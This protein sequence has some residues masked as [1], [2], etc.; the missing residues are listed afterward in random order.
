LPVTVAV[1][2][3]VVA[4]RHGV[5]TIRCRFG[6]CQHRNA[7][8]ISARIGLRRSSTQPSCPARS[9]AGA[10]CIN[11]S[12][13]PGIHVFAAARMKTWMASELGLVRVPL[14]RAASRVHPTWVTSPA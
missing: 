2:A 4:R 12:A 14:L 3:G 11:L 6:G 1:R 5:T 9:Q 13:L 10:D 8:V 7:D